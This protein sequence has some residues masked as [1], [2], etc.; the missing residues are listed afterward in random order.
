MVNLDERAIE[1]ADIPE[2]TAMYGEAQRLA[3]LALA[4]LFTLTHIPVKSEP[5]ESKPLTTAEAAA[6]VSLTPALRRKLR[7]C[8]ANVWAK[9]T[10]AS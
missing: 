3:A 8:S 10:A 9:W 4:R 1:S 2:L 5:E 7:S 6:L